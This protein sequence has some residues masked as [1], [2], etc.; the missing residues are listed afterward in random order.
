MEGAVFLG[1]LQETAQSEGQSVTR[2]C[3]RCHAPLADVIGD[4]ALEKK[5][6]WDGVSCDACHSITNVA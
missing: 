3:L 1:A 2:L 6:S 5:V 4:A